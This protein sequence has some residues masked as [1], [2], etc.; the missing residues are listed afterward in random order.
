MFGGKKEDIKAIGVCH[1]ETMYETLLTDEECAKAIKL[2]IFTTC[3]LIIEVQIMKYLKIL[4]LTII[5]IFLVVPNIYALG[6]I[7]QTTVSYE[8]FDDPDYA[9]DAT[10]YYNAQRT[11]NNEESADL[12]MASFVIAWSGFALTF[13]T[14]VAGILSFMGFKEVKDLQRARDDT[15]MLQ[16]KYAAEVAKIE[17]LKKESERNL[18]NLEKRFEN[19]AQSIMY[20]T[21]YYSMGTD[22]YRRAKY[23]EAIQYLRKSVQ[24]FCKNTDAICLIGR[25]YTFIGSEEI[26]LDYYQ[27]ALKIDENC[28]AAFRGMAA[29]YRYVEPK[30]ALEY[31]QR[32]ADNEPENPEIL[33]YYGQLLRDN[34]RISEAL[35]IY[36]RS[37]SIKKHPDT[38]FF[39]SILYLAEESY[40]R[41][42]LFIQE[43]IDGYNNEAEFGITKPVW[44]QLSIWVQRLV[45]CKTQVRF[46]VV[47]NQLEKVK[48]CIDTDKT[49]QVVLG[50]IEF[51]LKAMDAEETY[52]VESKKRVD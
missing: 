36:L 1:G 40:G 31:A 18:E 27:K 44:L 51:V 23:T 11:A 39:L 32:A 6:P 24:H 43:A 4:L 48:E 26:S 35:D 10:Q 52:I 25:A 42:R 47:M 16:E 5:G 41:A 9:D 37:Y 7:S 13:L 49:K 34:G 3:R 14:I 50:H 19:E 12:D 22:A 28:A 38:C 46:I 45:E 2:G 17:S 33:N 30:R 15:N 20:A 21:Y 29:W 8:V